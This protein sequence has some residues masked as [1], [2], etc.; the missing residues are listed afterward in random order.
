M[1]LSNSDF[2]NSL[3]TNV[4]LRTADAA[5]FQYFNGRLDQGLA[6]RS[7]VV[8]SFLNSSEIMGAPTQL[9]GVY[10]AALGRQPDSGGIQFWNNILMS[11]GGLSQIAQQMI[12]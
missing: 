11:G 4:L 10:H 9:A 7:Q 1:N 2:V 3:Y 12:G 8:E 6:T 5:G